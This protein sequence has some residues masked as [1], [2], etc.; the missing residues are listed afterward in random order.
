[1][2]GQFR[3]PV[4]MPSRYRIG[5]TGVVQGVGFRPFVKRLADRLGI[6]GTVTNTGAGVLI[7]IDA[8]R[9]SQ[10][11]GFTSAI[12]SEAPALARIES[13]SL[14]ALAFEGGTETPAG[15]SSFTILTSEAK[16]ESFTLVSADV[17]SCPDCL[18]EVN[19][20]HDR[21]FGYA[22]TN[23]TNCGPRYSITT[24]VPYDRANTTMEP[25]RMCAECLREYTNPGDRRFH[26][27]PTACPVCGPRLQIEPYAADAL[28]FAIAALQAGRIVA[29][30]GLGGFQLACDA[31][32]NLAVERLRTIK[33]RS[34]KPFAVMMRD[35]EMVA[36]YCD[37]TPG[38]LALLATGPAPI[39]LVK[40]RAGKTLSPAIAPSLSEL[41]VMLP[42]TPLHHLLFRS[43]LTCLVM[44]SGNISE[45]PI[46]ISSEGA[47]RKLAPLCD[48]LLTHDREIFMRV[49]D[50]VVRLHNG[51]PRLL[52]RA[53]GYAPEAIDLGFE[54]H[55]VLACG[56]D[57]K[58]TFCLTKGHY[59]VL[60][61]HIGDMENFETLEFF[62]ETLRKLK[63]VYRAA[64]R[65]IAHDPHP[66]YRTTRWAD[67]QPEPKIAVQHHHAHI[68]GCM[69][70]N[71]VHEKVIGIA[72]DGTGYGADGQSWGG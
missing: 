49:D 27:E 17:A 16:A 6:H 56:A 55:E 34:R 2:G 10:A 41:G 45:E 60:S 46:V 24:A 52:R 21:R 44:T 39:V 3:R 58:N 72:F 5:I 50:S 68:A 57:L 40:M 70:E 14:A 48:A 63:Q 15:F 43:G 32:S 36:A 8:E 1:M 7:E 61:Q 71:G 18:R 35:A 12:R 28:E 11:E 47:R 37:V 19:D 42:G 59:A 67:S 66:G 9:P 20:P 38:E 65:L 22:F 30:R 64:P 69:A 29:L 23:C 31:H 25:F 33:R 51:R 54:A 4:L 62:G 26:A 13:L 53:R